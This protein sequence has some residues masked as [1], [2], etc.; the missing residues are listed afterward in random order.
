[1]R[2][3]ARARLVVALVILGQ[4]VIAAPT[5]VAHT[6]YRTCGQGSLKNGSRIVFG[7]DQAIHVSVHNGNF[8]GLGVTVNHKANAAKWQSK[9]MVVP[10]YGTNNVHF[11]YWAPPLIR[12]EVSFSTP[13][14]VIATW[15]VTSRRCG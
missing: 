12:W 6:E 13:A 1:M 4:L 10:P 9:A 14:N 8:T 11:S 15:K 3:G 2:R 7:G 5:S